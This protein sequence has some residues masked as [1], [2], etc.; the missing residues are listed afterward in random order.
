[1]RK[2][3]VCVLLTCLFMSWAYAEV[4]QDT[5]IHRVMG[6]LYSLAS[7]VNLNNTV[8]PQVRQLRKYFVNIPEN[9]QDSVKV[10]RVKNSV[11]VGVLVGKY[12][13]ARKFLKSNAESMNIMESPGAHSWRGGD[14]AWL[15]A[16]DIRSNHLVPVKILASR[17]EDDDMF[18]STEGQKLW[19]QE[20]PKFSANSAEAILKKSGTILA[21]L[22]ESSKGTRHS[23]YNEVRPSGVG[24]PGKIHVGTKKS[25]F[26]MS[27]PIGDVIFNPIPNTR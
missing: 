4:E 8:S 22:H 13:S 16:A 11:W 20:N 7:A 25:S 23:I 14:Y 9:W 10:E 3:F 24:T 18:F 6:G 1:M 26:D 5:E 12:S 19:W 17:A 15:K 21:D 27:I 2:V